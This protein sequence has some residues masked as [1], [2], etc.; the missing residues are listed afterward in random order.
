MAK[1]KKGDVLSC[2]ACGLVLVVD[3]ACGCETAEV[4]CCDKPMAVKK[5]A[6]SRV[7]K[8]TAKPAAKKAKATAKKAKPAAKKKAASAKAA[9]RKPAKAAAKKK[10]AP[11]KK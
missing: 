6:A 2:E 7:K 1:A 10:A 11:A 9:A 3:E 5:P 4:I 8:L